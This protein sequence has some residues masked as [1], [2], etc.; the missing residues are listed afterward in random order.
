MGNAADD[1][2]NDR[3]EKPTI[4]VAGTNDHLSLRSD[5]TLHYIKEPIDY[6]YRPSVD[7][8]FKSLA[9]YWNRK[10]TAVLLTGMGQD[11][12][13]GLSLLRSIAG[14]AHDR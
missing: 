4:L 1:G 11:A 10:E 14:M 2:G 6:P 7:V 12:T 9:Q 8:F 5:F 3:L 13:E